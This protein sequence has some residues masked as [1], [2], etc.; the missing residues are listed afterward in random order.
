MLLR[1]NSASSPSK[2]TMS[3]LPVPSRCLS[4]S[5]P[6]IMQL[7]ALRTNLQWHEWEHSLLGCS[8][9]LSASTVSPL[10][11]T[12]AGA[13]GP[14]WRVSSFGRL[15]VPPC[16]R[17]IYFSFVP[18]VVFLC[19]GIP[20]APCGSV[21][22]RSQKCRKSARRLTTRPETRFH[23]ARKTIRRGCHES[24]DNRI[25][26]YPGQENLPSAAIMLRRHQGLS[27]HRDTRF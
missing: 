20:R 18:R 2:S 3:G 17:S 8:E 5:W 10:T 16:S 9:R 24:G 27:N 25:A 22:T 12:R 26:I 6:F 19:A 21:L 13:R 15:A 7:H 14:R 1:T 11:R 4:P 23:R